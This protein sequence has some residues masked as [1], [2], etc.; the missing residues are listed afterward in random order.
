MG[1]KAPFL[2]LSLLLANNIWSA[3]LSDETGEEVAVN[4]WILVEESIARDKEGNALET[5][6]KYCVITE[7][8][9]E[10]NKTP[11]AYAT[12]NK[13]H[14]LNAV[15]FAWFIANG[16]QFNPLP[17]G[18]FLEMLLRVEETQPCLKVVK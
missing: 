1:V 12:K 2:F 18:I 5:V 3:Y 17:Q 6:Y 16:T 10:R 11:S 7:V 4:D 14:P 9:D 15:G 13:P 8:V